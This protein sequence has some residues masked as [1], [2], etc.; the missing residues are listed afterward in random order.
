MILH[1]I[2]TWKQKVEGIAAPSTDKSLLIVRMTCQ[3]GVDFEHPG[4]WRKDHPNRR[5]NCN[6]SVQ[7]INHTNLDAYG[8]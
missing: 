4:Q 1:A 2:K 7:D 5:K 3:Q 6:F 8:P